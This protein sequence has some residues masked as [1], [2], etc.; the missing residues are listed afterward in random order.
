MANEDL[1]AAIRDLQRQRRR[2]RWRLYGIIVLVA[3]SPLMLLA[4][5]QYKNRQYR[6]SQLLDAAGA[7]EL[8]DLLGPMRENAAA[9]RAAWER[10]TKREAMAAL[11]IDREFACS[12]QLTAPTDQAAESYIRYRSID[13]NYFGS[14]PLRV[15][16][17][18]AEVGG[19][20]GCT[21]EG[22]MTDLAQ[23]L[24]SGEVNKWELEEARR[25]LTP[26]R[27][28]VLLLATKQVPAQYVDTGSVV[29]A[30]YISGLVQGRA[31]VYSYAD[32]SFVCGGDVEVE[33]SPKVDVRF[34]YSPGMRELEKELAT[35]EALKRDMEV[36]LRR[37]IASGL[38]VVAPPQDRLSDQ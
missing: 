34:L 9:C 13:G 19:D 35:K 37:R 11:R 27:H 2:G 29:G 24:D 7:R 26:R 16:G 20:D 18:D 36:Q 3:L 23:R 10:Q 22:Y 6:R 33:N 5:N 1:D 4:H 25:K 8:R 30:G 15:I 28:S 12:V 17:A 21:S 32:R 14:W 31:L 38:S